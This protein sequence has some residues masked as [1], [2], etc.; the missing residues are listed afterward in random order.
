ME[1]LQ[2][3]IIPVGE[4]LQYGQLV[5][6]VYQRPYKWTQKN[7]SQLIKDVY[8][9]RK[10]SAYRFGTIVIH[11]D[12]E[13][14]NIVDGQQRIITLLLIVQAIIKFHKT[15]VKNPELK[16]L[17]HSLDQKMFCPEFS[18][19][20]SIANISNNY[21]LIEREVVTFDEDLIIFLLNKCEVIQFVL[22]DVSEAF[23]FFDAQNARGRDLEPHDLLKAFHLRE[24][25]EKDESYKTQIV[26]TWESMQT[27]ELSGLFTDFLFRVKSWSRLQS[28]RYF[29]KNETDLFKGVNI[30]KIDAFAYAVPLRIAHRFV[31]NYNN[32]FERQVDMQQMPYPFQ[33]D[34]SIINGRRFFELVSHYK[35]KYST[36]KENIKSLDGT[37]SETSKEVLE[38]ISKYEGRHR[39]GD[40]YVRMLFDCALLFYI[41]RFGYT[42]INKA[43]ER[44][45]I[46][47]YSV[48]LNYQNVQLASVDNYVLQQQNLFRIVKDATTPTDFFSVNIPS[49]EN[50]HS[51]KTK[52][53]ENLFKSLKYYGS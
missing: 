42:E 8:T 48:R 49:V 47:A 18:N 20:I 23:Q 28:A 41:D 6:P 37:L 4:L 39:I 36:Y 51:T 46:W 44:I 53:I 17:L 29:T 13:N 34:Q 22:N 40:T 43:I 1:Q 31:D 21:Q 9:F 12:G 5:I 11:D 32:N 14:F 15:T 10:K 19:D 26:D 38:T 7:V 24:F 30:D 33:L 3:S 25:S 35:K 16:T 50:N 2:T 52:E 45:F 27:D